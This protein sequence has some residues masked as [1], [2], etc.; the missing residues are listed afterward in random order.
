MVV[1]DQTVPA[2]AQ[3]F[4]NR[5]ADYAEALAKLY[6]QKMTENE[7]AQS[8]AFFESPAG[9][10]WQAAQK[11]ANAALA[12]AGRAVAVKAAREARQIFCAQ[13]A[14]VN[15]APAPATGGQ[16]GAPAAPQGAKP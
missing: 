9:K 4:D 7:L 12:E 8:V 13:A 16:A 2:Y 5:E 11:E 1:H 15:T 14:C 3:A 6:R 10:I